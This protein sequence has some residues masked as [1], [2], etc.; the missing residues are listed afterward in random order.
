MKVMRNT[1]KNL[2]MMKWLKEN[3]F[4][5]KVLWTTA[6]ASEVLEE[7]TSAVAVSQRMK[8]C[9]GLHTASNPPA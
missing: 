6:T 7:E 5:L 8:V 2:M 1:S 9:V 4:G 3:G